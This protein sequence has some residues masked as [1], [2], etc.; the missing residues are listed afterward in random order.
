M[1]KRSKST[2]RQIAKE[3]GVSIDTVSRVL[4][5]RNKE[6][7]P[8]TMQRAATIRARTSWPG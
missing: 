5:G 6:L 2:L 3:A 7:W 1:L 4:N 8:G